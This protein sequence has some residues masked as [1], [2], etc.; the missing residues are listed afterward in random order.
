MSN[1]VIARLAA[2]NP[3]PGDAP[4]PVPEPLRV[5]KRAA[6][7][8]A[9]VA[10]LAVPAVAFAGKL[11]DLLGISNAGTSVSTSSV[12]PGQVNLDQAMQ[13]LNV[14]GTMQFLGTVNGASFYATRNADGNFC[15]AIDHTADQYEKGF[16]CD[17]NADN[18]PSADRQV[19]AFPPGQWLQG[20]AA[21]GVATVELLD[22]DGNV[23]AS[24]PVTNNLFAEDGVDAQGRAATIVTL[25]AN[26]NVTSSRPLP[27]GPPTQWSL[28]QLIGH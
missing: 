15:V 14:G 7:A 9:V 22:A 17:L 4:L 24:V 19:L 1:D 26:G 8:L 6:F 21:D 12:L 18:F 3:V 13:E 2:A 5:P 20:V 27:Q 11:G 10:L 25:D 16:G 23:I 28:D